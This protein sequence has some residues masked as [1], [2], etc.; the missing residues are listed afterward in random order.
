MH[1]N[2]LVFVVDTHTHTHTHTVRHKMK[3]NHKILNNTKHTYVCMTF[4][5]DTPTHMHA[6]LHTHTHT[7]LLT[8][9]SKLASAKALNQKN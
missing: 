6:P 4:S 9:S 7:H 2:M 1:Q 8:W 3:T 5:I